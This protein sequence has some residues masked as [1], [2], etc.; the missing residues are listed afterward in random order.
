MDELRLASSSVDSDRSSVSNDADGSSVEE[1]IASSHR[2]SPIRIH[3]LR[4]HHQPPIEHHTR[5]H[6]PPPNASPLPEENA[7]KRLQDLSHHLQ[8]LHELYAQE[9]GREKAEAR[10][11]FLQKMCTCS[12]TLLRHCTSRSKFYTAVRALLCQY[13][14]ASDAKLIQI[15]P[16]GDGH[17]FLV[18]PDEQAFDLRNPVGIAGHAVQALQQTLG[19]RD[20]DGLSASC[21]SSVSSIDGSLIHSA[22]SSQT[23]PWLAAHSDCV[24]PSAN[25]HLLLLFPVSS[26]RQ[27]SYDRSVDLHLRKRELAT[28][29]AH[30]LVMVVKD[31]SGKP[32]GVIEALLAT[33]NQ[34][35]VEFLDAFGVILASALE[36]RLVICRSVLD[37]VRIQ[38]VPESDE[39]TRNSRR[40]ALQFTH[41]EEAPVLALPLL[42]R[43]HHNV[44]VFGKAAIRQAHDRVVLEA[45][46]QPLTDILN[47]AHSTQCQLESYESVVIA[48][49]W[50]WS[51]SAE[52]ET[53]ERSF[54]ICR[55]ILEQFVQKI[56]HHDRQNNQQR[57][58]LRLLFH[59]ESMESFMQSYSGSAIDSIDSDLISIQGQFA[60]LQQGIRC[61]EET[62][63]GERVQIVPIRM[64]NA[65]ANDR[66]D[67]KEEEEHQQCQVAMMVICPMC[68]TQSLESC[69]SPLLLVIRK[70][71]VPCIVS[72]VQSV[73]WKRRQD[74]V[75]TL[76]T[77]NLKDFNLQHQELENELAHVRLIQLLDTKLR[78]CSSLDD[79]VVCVNSHSTNDTILGLNITK[80]TLFIA[81][82]KIADDDQTHSSVWTIDAATREK[83]FQYPTSID[84]KP[85]NACILSIP[86]YNRQ[87]DL[88]LCI[89]VLELGFHSVRKRDEFTLRNEAIACELERM[90]SA[91]IT[92]HERVDAKEQ[93]FYQL[94]HSAD[95]E[96]ALRWDRWNSF[97]QV[98]SSLPSCPDSWKENIVAPLLSLVPSSDFVNVFCPGLDDDVNSDVA[99]RI[100]KDTQDNGQSSSLNLINGAI[101]QSVLSFQLRNDSSLPGENKLQNGVIVFSKRAPEKFSDEEK[102][103][104]AMA[105]RYLSVYAIY[106]EKQLRLD[107]A[108]NASKE[109]AYDKANLEAQVCAQRT[110]LESLHHHSKLHS[111]LVKLINCEKFVSM[112]RENLGQGV[113]CIINECIDPPNSR[114][115]YG[116]ESIP[117]TC[118]ESHII[119]FDNSSTALKRVIHITADR[120]SNLDLRSSDELWM[121]ELSN[122]VE[123]IR[124]DG[125]SPVNR[126]LLRSF[127]SI[128]DKYTNFTVVPISQA[129][130]MN[131]YVVIASSSDSW[132]FSL[133]EESWIQL[134]QLISSLFEQWNLF[135]WQ[136]QE[137]GRAETAFACI[138]SG[139]KLLEINLSLCDFFHDLWTDVTTA[140]SRESSWH[141]W[142]K[143]LEARLCQELPVILCGCV[144]ISNLHLA[145]E[146]FSKLP[147]STEV[148]SFP[149][150]FVAKLKTHD[151]ATD[152]GVFQASWKNGSN[153]CYDNEQVLAVLHW[154]ADRLQILIQNG[155]VLESVM[156]SKSGL[157]QRMAQLAERDALSSRELEQ[158]GH[159]N[160]QFCYALNL[161]SKLLNIRV[162]HSESEDYLSQVFEFVNAPKTLQLKLWVIEDDKN[163]AST[164]VDGVRQIRSIQN[165]QD[166]RST[167]LAQF[168]TLIDIFDCEKSA[169][170]ESLLGYLELTHGE[171]TSESD[172]EL[173]TK[174]VVCVL[175]HVLSTRSRLKRICELQDQVILVANESRNNIMCGMQSSDRILTHIRLLDEEISKWT[176]CNDAT[177]ANDKA[178]LESRLKNLQGSANAILSQLSE[179]IPS[180]D[181]YMAPLVTVKTLLITK[182]ERGQ[183][184]TWRS[185]SCTCSADSCQSGFD[186]KFL[187]QLIADIAV[188][189]SIIANANYSPSPHTRR[190]PDPLISLAFPSCDGKKIFQHWRLV[191]SSENA[192]HQLLVVPAFPYVDGDYNSI[193]EANMC[194]VL[195]C[196]IEGKD[197]NKCKVW[198]SILTVFARRIMDAYLTTRKLESLTASTGTLKDQ[199]QMSESR[200]LSAIQMQDKLHRFTEQIMHLLSV[201]MSST[202]ISNAKMVPLIEDMVRSACG[203][204][205]IVHL[206]AFGDDTM[207]VDSNN[208][209]PSALQ[210]NT[211]HRCD[212]HSIGN[213]HT[214]ADISGK[215]QH[216]YGKVLPLFNATNTK[217]G[218]LTLQF[219]EDLQFSD[220]T[221]QL[222]GRVAYF[223]GLIV[224]MSLNNKA[225][226]ERSRALQDDY[227][228]LLTDKAQLEVNCLEMK[229]HLHSGEADRAVMRKNMDAI[230]DIGSQM[231]GFVDHLSP[232][233]ERQLLLEA[234]TKAVSFIPSVLATQLHEYNTGMANNILFTIAEEKS[235]RKLLSSEK[236]EVSVQ[237][238]VRDAEIVVVDIDTSC[239]GVSIPIK[240]DMHDGESASVIF[241]SSPERQEGLFVLSVIFTHNSACSL[242]EYYLDQLEAMAQLTNL[243]LRSITQE[244]AVM[245][246]VQSMK[247]EE[248]IAKSQ[249]TLLETKCSD[250]QLR[251]DQHVHFYQG[252]AEE[253]A[254]ASALTTRLWPASVPTSKLTD[255]WQQ[256]LGIL[257][258]RLQRMLSHTK[259]VAGQGI[260]LY[261]VVK[262]GSF[263]F[264]LPLNARSSSSQIQ[265]ISF[266]QIMQSKSTQALWKVYV[267]EHS[268][269]VDRS[270]GNQDTN[271]DK[272][273]I[274]T[275]SVIYLPVLFGTDDNTNPDSHRVV[276]VMEFRTEV[277]LDSM[278]THIIQGALRVIAPYAHWVGQMIHRKQRQK[279]EKRAA[280]R[281]YEAASGSQ[282]LNIAASTSARRIMHMSIGKPTNEGATAFHLDASKPVA[283]NNGISFN[284][285]ESFADDDEDDDGSKKSRHN[286]AA[287]LIPFLLEMHHAGDTSSLNQLV[288][289][290]V[291]SIWAPRVRSGKRHLSTCCIFISDQFL[292]KCFSRDLD[293][294]QWRVPAWIKEAAHGNAT[295]LIWKLK[296]HSTGDQHWLLE[297]P[298]RSAMTSNHGAE[299]MGYLLVT[300]SKLEKIFDENDESAYLPQLSEAVGLRLAHISEHIALR[301]QGTELINMRTHVVEL[302]SKYEQMELD[303]DT[304][305]SFDSFVAD[306]MDVNSETELVSMAK[307]QLQ[308]MHKCSHVVFRGANSQHTQSITTVQCLDDP[309][310]HDSNQDA[311]CALEMKN[312]M[313]LH[314]FAP[315]LLG[316]ALLGSFVVTMDNQS[317]PISSET[318]KQLRRFASMVGMALNSIR[319]I[320]S[321][322]QQQEAN[323]RALNETQ[324]LEQA[325]GRL[326]AQILDAEQDKQQL[327]QQLDWQAGLQSSNA[328]LA[329]EVERLTSQLSEW[330]QWKVE[331]DARV[332]SREKAMAHLTLQL[333]QLRNLEIQLRQTEEENSELRDRERKLEKK[334]VKYRL[335]LKQLVNEMLTVK[336]KE[337]YEA[338]ERVKLETQVAVLKETQLREPGQAAAVASTLHSHAHRSLHQLRHQ[339]QEQKRKQLHLA[340]ELRQLAAMEARELKSQEKSV[341]HQN[342]VVHTRTRVAA[343]HA[344]RNTSQ[345][346][347][348]KR[349]EVV[350][351]TMSTIHDG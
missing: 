82:K 288:Q 206:C 128:S 245:K 39:A 312:I 166:R 77:Q 348:R 24:Y 319:T 138:Q 18:L 164:V 67:N 270:N 19:T 89:G 171:Q 33:A 169:S 186:T 285:T 43:S 315:R 327:Q 229:N 336:R 291:K 220:E 271:Q 226:S 41:S 15:E 31:A 299:F 297:I 191:E 23:F 85:S 134:S 20:S 129:G 7:N 28:R 200:A 272:R 273:N 265:C 274:S 96:N 37:S 233:T 159:S 292:D 73:L 163:H 87:H 318:Q 275:V 309:S 72:F 81:T 80:F 69:D 264:S 298:D 253:L 45:L 5:F 322:T 59:A 71:A 259:P 62:T 14:P 152:V 246:H 118:T 260:Q 63:A 139:K 50:L 113:I 198:E 170:S 334:L 267:G 140:F 219:R 30:L 168:P 196:V 27:A 203:N 269:E 133:S 249:V 142:K 156:I 160:K 91:F 106:F 97:L 66:S 184:S 1:S 176:S 241:P 105:A 177:S 130:S 252:F 151:S 68:C 313:H 255:L 136:N 350:P 153:A 204:D 314:V 122:H 236:V 284:D 235:A 161:L 109:I 193:S 212:S 225:Q 308:R 311:E 280:Q 55:R 301:D 266:A 21:S 329:A 57:I 320:T 290:A 99:G 325:N 341:H 195:L 172:R 289:H 239:V 101:L 88:Q 74:A 44:L 231:A 107:E 340:Q 286:V 144:E 261:G 40:K 4:R 155:K 295:G 256:L 207:N 36:T 248:S 217:I 123:P 64:Q 247:N 215:V 10:E 165:W 201:A 183:P 158:V 344:I 302:T 337:E 111:R 351:V 54:E 335:Q 305:K 221:K 339:H 175:G 146:E 192:T 125:L 321:N 49:E 282:E 76:M 238:S 213:P 132:L 268:V 281:T 342:R 141:Q 48:C 244:I 17:A 323:A 330:T 95:E 127:I 254:G 218:E 283:F 347:R 9:L 293:K 326:Q 98:C 180:D 222:V 104:G 61:A 167:E 16:A 137:K 303:A 83:I 262:E 145:I 227:E 29:K 208:T 119:L 79:V 11:S 194:V 338:H 8:H 102:Q 46:R 115:G 306:I 12:I 60:M 287:R 179:V 178:N 328:H 42:D 202:S 56:V 103:T 324:R 126:N 187:E 189:N 51:Q 276:G 296:Q 300:G 257:H 234:L 143:T 100:L 224:G 316:S 228:K 25:G 131:G 114:A 258:Y 214:L 332:A 70:Y 205:T 278:E 242:K 188:D 310:V 47:H 78:M 2:R 181:T 250:W 75:Q 38:I 174:T 32:V 277:A 52:I 307:S 124:S 84:R 13:V 148:N 349:V 150:Q 263:W 6:M 92:M 65:R 3:P 121:T 157:N 116:E 243:R 112:T 199:G 230:L 147:G 34:A 173:V 135:V 86:I 232:L 154:I 211:T 223:A 182:N 22:Q 94:Q 120:C 279:I 108:L 333:E 110:V 149:Y 209:E 345:D 304:S 343:H 197:N 240:Q 294:S 93:R 162:D 317:L 237:K 53:G 216:V 331:E 346:D 117:Q 210:L 58:Q 35:Q 251:Y 190:V 185:A 26:T 90:S